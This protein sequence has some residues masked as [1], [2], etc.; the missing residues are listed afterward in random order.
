MF[1]V[2]CNLETYKLALILWV[3]SLTPPLKNIT[4]H[5]HS[6]LQLHNY[7]FYAFERIKANAL[8]YAELK[9][10]Y[11]G[12]A[13]NISNNLKIQYFFLKKHLKKNF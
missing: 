11:T 3:N 12:P 4:L 6:D 9:F 1:I 8:F 13:F 7:Q 10:Y 2:K 5:S